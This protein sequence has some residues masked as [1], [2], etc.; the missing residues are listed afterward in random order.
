[1]ARVGLDK[2]LVENIVGCLNS[3]EVFNDDEQ[4]DGKSKSLSSL[5]KNKNLAEEILGSKISREELANA[6]HDAEFDAILLGKVWAKY[7]AAWS[8][9]PVSV[10]VDNYMDPSANLIR[11]AQNFIT[12]IG[13]RRRRRVKPVKDYGVLIFNGWL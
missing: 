3:L 13:D 6:A 5:K 11:D 8:P 1:M 7:L 10:I 2:E 12:K 4:F 9:E